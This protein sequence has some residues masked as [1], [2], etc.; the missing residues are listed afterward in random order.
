MGRNHDF[1]SKMFFLAGPKN[2][3]GETFC[4]VAQKSSGS[5]KSKDGRGGK[6]S[7]FSVESF[8]SHSAEKNRRGINYWVNNS[9]Y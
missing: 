9:G 2:F 7:R 8:L 3:V 5:E 1:P 6:V 4:A